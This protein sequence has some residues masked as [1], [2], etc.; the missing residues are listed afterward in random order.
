MS[1]ELTSRA[2]IPLRIPRDL[3]EAIQVYADMSGMSVNAAIL[4]LIDRGL[5]LEIVYHR[6]LDAIITREDPDG[7]QSSPE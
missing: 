1:V 6:G 3:R 7:D 5:A 2:Q 4:K